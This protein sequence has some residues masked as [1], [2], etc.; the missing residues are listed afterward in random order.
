MLILFQFSQHNHN[1]HQ[2]ARSVTREYKASLSDSRGLGRWGEPTVKTKPNKKT[3]WQCY[4][5][6]ENM[7]THNLA[8]DSWIKLYFKISISFF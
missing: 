2:N 7:Y 6:C 1:V 8:I 3:I 4:Q 5:N